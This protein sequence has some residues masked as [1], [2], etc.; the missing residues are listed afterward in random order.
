MTT[1]QDKQT[2]LRTRLAWLAGIWCASVA[3]LGLAAYMMR[4]MMRCAGLSS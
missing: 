2:P 4:L 3:T 1:D